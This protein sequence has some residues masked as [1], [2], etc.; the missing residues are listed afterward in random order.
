MDAGNYSSS[1]NLRIGREEHICED[2]GENCSLR[3]SAFI[4]EIHSFDKLSSAINDYECV[5]SV[6]LYTKSF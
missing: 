3:T 1:A 5:N 6:T 2:D 4:I